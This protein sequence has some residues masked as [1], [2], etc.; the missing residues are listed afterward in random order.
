M[1][2]LTVRPPPKTKFFP[3]NGGPWAGPPQQRRREVGEK[4]VQ[5]NGGKRIGDEMGCAPKTVHGHRANLMEKLGVSND[6][7]LARRMFDGW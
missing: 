6:V 4:R 1:E 7:E 5:G 2:N 3:K